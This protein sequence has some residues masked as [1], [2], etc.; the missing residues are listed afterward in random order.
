[1]IALA[2]HARTQLS[3]ATLTIMQPVHYHNK[4]NISINKIKHMEVFRSDDITA[5]RSKCSSATHYSYHCL[6][7]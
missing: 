4:I 7:A 3:F 1:M 2:P 6:S 5:P